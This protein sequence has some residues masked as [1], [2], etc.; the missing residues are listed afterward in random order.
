MFVLELKPVGVLSLIFLQN[1]FARTA[2]RKEHVVHKI[3]ASGTI[4]GAQGD[5]SDAQPVIYSKL[6]VSGVRLITIS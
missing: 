5:L 1:I 6:I 3:S 2:G 4:D